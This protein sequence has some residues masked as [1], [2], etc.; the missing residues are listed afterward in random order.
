MKTLKVWLVLAACAYGLAAIPTAGAQTVTAATLAG[1]W[2]GTLG[3]QLPLVLHL[4]ADASGALTATLDSPVQGANGLA[5]A[6]VKLDGA[7][8]QF[9][10]PSVAGNYTG[11]VSADGKTISGTWTQTVQ[12][13]PHAQPLEWTY[14]GTA[15]QAAAAEAAVKPSPIDGDWAGAISAGGQTL[16]VVFHFKSAPDGI[17][18]SMVSVDQSPQPIPCSDV[19]GDGRK[20]SFAAKAINGTYDGKLRADGKHIDGTWNQGTPLEL[21]LTK[22]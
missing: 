14:A 6:N 15:A 16:H 12:G 20:V 4:S 2:K 1:E 10:I 17:L 18:C 3:G 13:Q 5:G 22:K 19:K 8:F 7:A 9:D 11:T 21:D